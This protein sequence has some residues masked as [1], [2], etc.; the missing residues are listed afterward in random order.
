[1]WDSAYVTCGESPT[2]VYT[3]ISTA[4]SLAWHTGCRV[5][6]IREDKP[7][8]TVQPIPQ[9]QVEVDYMI[10]NDTFAQTAELK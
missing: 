1:M 8:L 10:D 6:P 9:H 4:L 2:C 7:V 5:P 3:I